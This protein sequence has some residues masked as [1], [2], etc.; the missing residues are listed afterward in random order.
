[1]V[2]KVGRRPAKPDG[3]LLVA[4]VG[5]DRV[6]QVEDANQRQPFLTGPDGRSENNRQRRADLMP[7][8]AM[9]NSLVTCALRAAA[10]AAVLPAVALAA[11]SAATPGEGVAA[12]AALSRDQR[13]A[14][15]DALAVS[16]GHPPDDGAVAGAAAGAATTPAPTSSSG[17][18]A[19]SA[20]ATPAGTGKWRTNRS[21]NE[22]DDSET[23]TLMLDADSGRAGYQNKLAYFVARCQSNKT[24]VY[25]NWNAYL[26][27][28]SNDVYNEWKY[29]TVRI[30]GDEA[31]R[32]RWGIS[33]D[34]EATFAPNW[35][36]DLLKKMLG[37]DRLVVQTTP[38]GANPVTAEFDISGLAT[39]LKPLA[40]TCGWSYQ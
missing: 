7:N 3:I 36:G 39:A 6:E 11:A 8:P 25:I 28:D 10:A 27:D 1:M 29:V 24:E 17:P 35:A 23:V 33:T 16:L 34:N 19:A 31:S 26:G 15:Y 21:R 40:E 2:V 13:L 5:D 9:R 20:A 32:Q 4:A 37:A 30:G 38:Y 12:C 22:L 18:A 14:C